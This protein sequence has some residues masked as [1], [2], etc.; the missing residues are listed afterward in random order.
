M[1]VIYLSSKKLPYETCDGMRRNLDFPSYIAYLCTSS[2][3]STLDLTAI[4][5]VKCQHA[6]RCSEA[7][8]YLAANNN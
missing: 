7:L 5:I 2:L 3:G 1:P 8:K 4:A 6:E